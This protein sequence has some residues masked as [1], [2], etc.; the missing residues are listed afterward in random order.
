MEGS[1]KTGFHIASRQ[2]QR[3]GRESVVPMINIVFLLLIF[4]LMTARIAPPDLFEVTP[5][6]AAEGGAPEARAALHIAADGRLAYRDARGG[7]VWEALA[8][9]APQDDTL[10]IRADADL[11]GAELARIL[12]RLSRS[13]LK[14]ARLVT[15]G[16]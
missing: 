12:T 2:P 10:V 6:A 5:P 14:R 9:E 3:R 13:G 15:V 11:A 1:V 16:G 7:A 4:F 8:T